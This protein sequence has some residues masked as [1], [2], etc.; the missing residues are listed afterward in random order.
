MGNSVKL[1]ARKGYFYYAYIYLDNGICHGTIIKRL[2]FIS[3][4]AIRLIH[5]EERLKDMAMSYTP[6]GDR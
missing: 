1:W 5:G 4:H 3:Y 6:M 2:G